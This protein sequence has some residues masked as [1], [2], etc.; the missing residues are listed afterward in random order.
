M[1]AEAEK[2]TPRIR[3]TVKIK[4]SL[5]GS[6]CSPIAQ[7]FPEKCSIMLN[8]DPGCMEVLSAK[9]T[10][11]TTQAQC[12]VG[13]LRECWTIAPSNAATVTSRTHAFNITAL[14]DWGRYRRPNVDSI[15]AGVRTAKRV[16][17]STAVHLRPNVFAEAFNIEKLPTLSSWIE[18][19]PADPNS[20]H[21]PEG[22]KRG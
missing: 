12:S 16:H 10:A 5:Q 6:L 9:T 19:L 2:D 8:A 4:K 7:V 11:G 22:T 3:G 13:L 14:A 17:T 20:R 1:N 21:Q 15:A 18:H